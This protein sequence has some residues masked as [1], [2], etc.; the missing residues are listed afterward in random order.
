MSGAL[1]GKNRTL[2]IADNE[3]GRCNMKEKQITQKLNEAFT[4]EFSAYLNEAEWWGNDDVRVW[5]FS[6]P[7]LGIDIRMELVEEKRQVQCF[8]RNTLPGKKDYGTVDD[9]NWKLRQIWTW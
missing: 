6:L 3:K 1:T 5:A 2:I 4:S 9:R 7:S 8:E